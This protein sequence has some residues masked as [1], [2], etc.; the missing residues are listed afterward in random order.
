MNM[1]KNQSLLFNVYE[2]R[3]NTF[4][5]SIKDET[6]KNETDPT[7]D[8]IHL[9]KLGG[10]EMTAVNI[11]LD[12]ETLGTKPGCKIISIGATTFSTDTRN[13]KQKFYETIMVG[14]QDQLKSDQKTLEWWSK[15]SEEAQK[16]VFD[17]PNSIRLTK[18]LYLFSNWLESLEATPIIWC[19]G[20]G[21]DAPI[22]EAACEIYGF[23]I[24]W[25]FRNVRCVRTVMD[26]F[27]EIKAPAFNGVKHNALADAEHQAGHLIEI[28]KA[29]RYEC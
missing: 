10:T 18:A 23:T 14:L 7:L 8:Q 12:L 3:T 6:T 1:S 28:F 2:S 29:I 19:K 9:L 13:Q 24:P 25:K 11:M 27:P 20:A 22:L 17:N 15:Q 4:P 26:M 5:E 16:E 21:F